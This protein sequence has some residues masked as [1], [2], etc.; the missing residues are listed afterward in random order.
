MYNANEV[1]LFSKLMLNKTMELKVK[2]ARVVKIKGEDYCTNSAG[3]DKLLPRVIKKYRSPIGY[4]KVQKPM[5]FKESG[6]SLL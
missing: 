5:M 6:L 4:W 1:T 3:T 2:G